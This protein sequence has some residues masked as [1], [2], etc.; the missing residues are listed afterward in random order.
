MKSKEPKAP[1]L[2]EKSV[3]DLPEAQSLGW[4]RGTGKRAVLCPQGFGNRFRRSETPSHLKQ[5]PRQDP[6]HIIKEAVSREIELQLLTFSANLNGPKVPHRGALRQP[7][8][9]PPYPEH[10]EHEA[11]IAW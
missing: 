6:H 3:F 7:V 1:F 11:E 8:P 9:W 10:P 5:R 4:R 2:C